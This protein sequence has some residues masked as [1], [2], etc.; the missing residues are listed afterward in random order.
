MITDS[1][2]SHNNGGNPKTTNPGTSWGQGWY[3]YHPGDLGYKKPEGA[4]S[5]WADGH[6]EWHAYTVDV[7]P[8]ANRVMAG[9]YPEGWGHQMPNSAGSAKYWTK[10]SRR[11]HK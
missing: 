3:D 9:T 8:F 1:V 5:V 10:Q 6:V 7:V 11:T 4:N 2:I